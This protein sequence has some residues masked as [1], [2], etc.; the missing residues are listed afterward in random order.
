MQLSLNNFYPLNAVGA[1]ALMC[2]RLILSTAYGD[3]IS[4]IPISY[5][6]VNKNVIKHENRGT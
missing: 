4:K 1:T 3:Q 5:T 6:L 2:S